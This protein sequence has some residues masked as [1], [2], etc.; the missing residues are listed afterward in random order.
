MDE[1]VGRGWRQGDGRRD[2]LHRLDLVLQRR[3]VGRA[4]RQR[5]P[6]RRS[7]VDG[8]QIIFRQEV[9]A[10]LQIIVNFKRPA[11]FESRSE[12]SDRRSFRQLPHALDSPKLALGIL[13][14]HLGS[15]ARPTVMGL[16]GGRHVDSVVLGVLLVLLVVVEEGHGGSVEE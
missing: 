9:G 6:V 10:E 4:A 8:V 13:S 2:L 15:T 11:G 16:G 1:G 14:G 7:R 3:G 5:G 12:R